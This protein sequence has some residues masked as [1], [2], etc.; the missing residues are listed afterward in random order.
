ME[1]FK[2][3]NKLELWRAFSDG[4]NVVL[5]I[6]QPLRV[7]TCKTYPT[8]EKNV[9]PVSETASVPLKLWRNG[10]T[11]CAT[12]K[13]MFFFT[14]SEVYR[15]CKL[16]C[17]QPVKF[18]WIFAFM[19]SFAPKFIFFDQPWTTTASFLRKIF[20]FSSKKCATWV[21]KFWYEI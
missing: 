20:C 5:Q 7:C 21:L 11:I 9:I 3:G 6:R 17:Q 12:T 10:G 2:H 1:L 15:I 4:R 8:H 16:R 19:Q 14:R 13:K 18:L